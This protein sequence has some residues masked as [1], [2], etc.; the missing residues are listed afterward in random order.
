MINFIKFNEI[1]N[2]NRELSF[3]LHSIIITIGPSNSGKTYF[4]K[5]ILVPGLK[6]INNNLN[7]QYISSDDTRADLLGLKEYNKYDHF[8]KDISESA[9]DLLYMK[10][11][12]LARFPV[13]TEYIIIDSTGLSEVFRNKIEKLAEKHHYSLYGIVFNYKSYDMYLNNIKDSQSKRI[14]TDH[15]KRFKEKTLR[16]IK[17]S[18]YNKIYKVTE[19]LEVN[20]FKINVLN[21]NEYKKTRI[22]PNNKYIIIGDLHECIDELKALL[23]KNRIKI[24]NNLI[25]CSEN[26]KII[27]VG[28]YIDKGSKTSEIINFL[29][30][31]RE[32]FILIRGNHEEFTYRHL[33]SN[34]EI[35]KEYYTAIHVLRNYSILKQ[36]FK[37]LY[38]L[39]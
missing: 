33:N 4:C 13:M 32:H 3:N 11:D 26:E 38:Q 37:V 5:N 19:Q 2:M 25:E 22:S 10:I 15:I 28:D 12:A 17:Y 6:S 16:E 27:L 14:I 24:N 8:M 9:F 35:I 1:V 34:D 7:V 21:I 20:E 18:L 31:N 39:S 30:D 29:Y 36:K 23:E